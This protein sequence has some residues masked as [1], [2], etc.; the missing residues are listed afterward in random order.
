MSKKNPVMERVLALHNLLM[1]QKPK[2]G[3]SP[4]LE[5]LNKLMSTIKRIGLIE[6]MMISGGNG[7]YLIIDGPSWENA[8]RNLGVVKAPSFVMWEE[9]EFLSFLQSLIT[10]PRNKK[11]SSKS[12]DAKRKPAAGPKTRNR[13]RMSPK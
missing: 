4:G 3:S 12:A 9:M 7:R 6:K 11:K 13:G 8:C 10:L 5:R 1:S 2:N